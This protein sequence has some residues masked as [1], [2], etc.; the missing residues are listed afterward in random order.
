MFPSSGAHKPTPFFRKLSS[1]PSRV[2]PVISPA[3]VE[4][5]NFL[6]QL[7]V[8]VFIGKPM[9]STIIPC[10]C[11]ASLPS[12][13][14]RRH[15][16]QDVFYTRDLVGVPVSPFFSAVPRRPSRFSA[17]LQRQ[18][19]YAVILYVFNHRACILAAY[20]KYPIWFVPCTLS[21][22]SCVQSLGSQIK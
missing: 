10:C 9:P 7:H 3:E 1:P 5:R 2:F 8:V 14:A 17:N 11:T 16:L 21:L 12:V 4:L 22:R 20:V 15:E 6:F 13:S 18:V 19:Q